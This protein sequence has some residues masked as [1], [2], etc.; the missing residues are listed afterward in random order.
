MRSIASPAKDCDFGRA[1]SDAWGGVFFVAFVLLLAAFWSRDFFCLIAYITHCEIFRV[2]SNVVPYV[3]FV[4]G[5]VAACF[6]LRRTSLRVTPLSFLIVV[7]LSLFTL[8]RMPLP[9]GS[10]DTLNYHLFLQQNILTDN[11][12]WNFFPATFWSFF[13]PL[14]DGIF[15]GF[16]TLL[17]YR[18]GTVLNT[19]IILLIYQQVLRILTA[20]V[21]QQGLKVSIS[22]L[23]I[24]SFL[25]IST[26]I[27]LLNVATYLGDLLAVPLLIAMFGM[28]L[29]DEKDV[30]PLWYAALL[31]GLSIALKLSYAPFAM[32]F[33][34]LVL[35]RFRSRVEM[36]KIVGMTTLVL[37]PISIYLIYSY[38]STKNPLFP[39]YNNVFQSIFWPL[40][41]YHPPGCGPE[42]IVQFILWPFWVVASPA[43]SFQLGVYSGRIALTTA[44][45]FFMGLFWV[46]T[47]IK[48]RRWNSLKGFGFAVLAYTTTLYLWVA[49]AVGAM[50]Y[51]ITLEI[52]GGILFCALIFRA[53]STTS[54]CRK[55]LA[56]AGA[57]LLIVQ[58][59][60]CYYLMLK[61]NIDWSWRPGF[62]NHARLYVD[63]MFMLGRDRT[64]SAEDQKRLGAVDAWVVV[65]ANSGCAALL[66]S[67]VPI[68][69]L[70]AFGQFLSEE[71]SRQRN[72][73]EF[74][75]NQFTSRMKGK[76]VFAQLGDTYCNTTNVYE[77]I[78]LL[79]QFGYQVVD[80]FWVFPTFLPRGQAVPV[81]ELDSSTMEAQ[82]NGNSNKVLSVN[83]N[84]NLLETVTD[85]DSK[86]MPALT[87]LFDELEK[88]PRYWNS[89][90][91]IGIAYLGGG[92][93]EK[94]AA[95]FEKS[96]EALREKQEE[97]P[98][99]FFYLAAVRE[100][101][102]RFED[103]RRLFAVAVSEEMAL[104]V[105]EK[106]PNFS[107]GLK[108]MEA[109]A[110]SKAPI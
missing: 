40:S 78:K 50:R 19:L 15:G 71:R 106:N 31:A 41:N 76:R 84:Q 95:Y 22:W 90:L 49:I 32:V 30:P 5:I 88:S 16:R 93:L 20:H 102:G 103:A 69:N 60:G 80:V 97:N 72:A 65:G 35:A 109:Q 77:T 89:L 46:L 62:R 48:N 12:Y 98:Y 42:N 54:W 25:I 7:G 56:C 18:L 1:C 53:F 23:E 99:P 55:T 38:L 39:F 63:N 92:F 107:E 96:V 91:S 104:K 58:V 64:M 59:F 9:D 68:A 82:K 74:A 11:V 21:K 14:V 86:L 37:L 67:G 85:L 3:V 24:F 108:R 26:E 57:I 13:P 4:C 101:Q 75:Y 44:V 34:I 105:K 17:G 83:I 100:R 110:G 52:C 81:L 73:L 27:I 70:S 29:A 47:V 8:L 87:P 61:K 51:G 10:T 79:G 2:I 28:L 43:R 36:R 33:L 45:V 94:A 6:L 66:K